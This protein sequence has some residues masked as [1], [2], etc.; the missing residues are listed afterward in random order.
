M[1]P[2]L[3]DVAY[4]GGF[5][6]ASP[7][8][9]YKMATTGKYRAGLS[10]R[11]GFVPRRT[12]ADCIW[13]HGVSVGELLAARSIVAG[14]QKALPEVPLAVSTT[15]N[16][17]YERALESYSGS[18]VFYYPLDFSWAVSRVFERIR[19]A[20]VV[21]MEMEVWPN[22][23]S[24]ACGRG[25][26]VV[27]ANGR[28]TE[29]GHRGY[30]RFPRLAR[31][32]L[33][34]VRLYLMQNELYAERLRSLGVPSGKVRVVGNVKFDTVSIDVDLSSR[35]A[36]RRE[37]GV[38]EN[39]ILIIGGSTHAGEEQALLASYS[40]LSRRDP[41]VRLLVVP[42]HRTRFEEVR[43]LIVSQG[44]EVFA[45]SSLAG[46]GTPAGGEVLLGDTM[47]ELERLYEAADIAFVGG[48]LIPHGGQ[49]ILEPAARGK[50]VVFGPSMENFPS[51]GEL[52]LTA[53]AAVRIGG[54]DELSEALAGF[55]DGP[56]AAAAGEAGRAAIIGSRGATARTVEA[57]TSI[58]NEKQQRT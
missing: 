52:L 58:M 24:R 11:L 50:P 46:G 41:R 17:G 12:G 21:L 19:P 25:V 34:K 56:K 16:T 20:I 23:L 48:S 8:F 9:L 38:G 51:A 49:N 43:R 26:P 3:L 1:N 7:Y 44:F 47:G 13:L 55:L 30:A 37:M 6:A 53:G 18:H 31:K 33:S 28:I 15:T 22:F 10:Q 27:V 42:R 39:E 35:R 4:A 29:R 45:R 57:I 5:L 36:L 2:Y 32:M 14:L 40:R 54:A